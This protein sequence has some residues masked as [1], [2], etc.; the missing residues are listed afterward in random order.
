MQAYEPR[1]L[2]RN[3]LVEEALEQEAKATYA[4]R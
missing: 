4:I 2:A 1:L 3:H